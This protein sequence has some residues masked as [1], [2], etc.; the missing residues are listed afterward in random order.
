MSST[1]FQDSARATTTGGTTGT[2][3]VLFQSVRL[4]FIWTGSVQIPD[5][6][7]SSVLPVKFTAFDSGIPIGSWYNDQSSPNLQV[8]QQLSVTT[9]GLATGTYVA[10]FKGMITPAAETPPFWP[11]PTPAP[12][13]SQ[14]QTLVSVSGFLPGVGS[15]LLSAYP[16]QAAPV[17]LGTSLEVLL[18]QS[19]TNSGRLTIIWSLTALGNT[20]SQFTLDVPNDAI[21]PGIS[22]LV[23]PNLGNFVRITAANATP[24]TGTIDAIINTGLPPIT[25]PPIITSGDLTRFNAAIADGADSGE[26]ILPSYVGDAQL[27]LTALVAGA[28]PAAGAIFAILRSKDYLGATSEIARVGATT[29]F[30]AGA[31]T[32]SLQPG[33]IWKM[34][35]R[36]NS[37]QV[38]NRIGGGVGVSVDMAISVSGP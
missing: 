26:I 34:S 5:A 27:F 4:G 8:Q 30:L 2:L 10:F 29:Q 28:S 11:G 25:R 15:S 38:Y 18:F 12:P 23:V 36:I 9:S 33:Y 19:I 7:S 13:P 6:V 21:A 17:Q 3:S 32:T 20:T 24:A 37:I 1:A 22:G 31:G 14:P 35:P 16:S